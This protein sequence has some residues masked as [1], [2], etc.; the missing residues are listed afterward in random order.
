MAALHDLSLRHYDMSWHN[1]RGLD[2]RVMIRPPALQVVTLYYRAPELL[3][4][5][6]SYT[7]A[8]DLWSVGCIMAEMVN[9]EALFKSDTEVRG[10]VGECG[11]RGR[12]CGLG[13]RWTWAPQ[14]TTAARGF[15]LLF[16]AS[17]RVPLPTSASR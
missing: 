14:G 9:F 11:R 15:R 1:L 4:G 10:W 13:C 5:A 17:R 12:R 3:L 2:P 16:F 7:A 6:P 8:V